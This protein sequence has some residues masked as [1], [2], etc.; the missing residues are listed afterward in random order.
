[1]RGPGPGVSASGG[2]ADWRSV[3]AEAAG[4]ARRVGLM[5][6]LVLLGAVGAVVVA[7]FLVGVRHGTPEPVELPLASAEAPPPVAT[8]QPSLLQVHLAGAV[9]QPGLYEV[10]ASFR[11]GDL[12]DA[13][14]GF[15]ADADGAAVN[16]AERLRDGQ[17]IYVPVEGELPTVEA[18]GS[19]LAGPIDVNAAT[20]AQLAELPGIGPS[21]AAAIIAFRSEH[22]P[23]ATVDALEQV[24]GIG[25]SKLSQ[26]RPRATV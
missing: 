25:P 23:F 11:V 15:E 21:L 18:P 13:A 10:P 6:V 17:Q 7:G 26:L 1:M 2:S 24:P 12:V 20:A 8:A 14:G 19:D 5:P 9:G 16:L 22:G 4:F 3:A